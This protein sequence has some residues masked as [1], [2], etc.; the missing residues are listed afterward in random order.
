LPAGFEGDAIAVPFDFVGPFRSGRRLRL[1]EGQAWFDTRGHRV[2]GKMGLRRVAR[3]ASSG[4]ERFLRGNK[5]LRTRRL[6]HQTIT[7]ENSY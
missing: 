3:L 4:A 2:E 1:Q 5:W 7:L 6:C